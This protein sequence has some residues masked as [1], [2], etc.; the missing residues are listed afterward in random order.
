MTRFGLELRWL[1]EMSMD[2]SIW[3]PSMRLCWSLKC[4]RSIEKS[5]S[6]AAEDERTKFAILNASANA[7]VVLPL[8]LKHWTTSLEPLHGLVKVL[9]RACKGLAALVEVGVLE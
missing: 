1:Y 7:G 4:R 9:A 8:S 5:R 3:S 6:T 2:P